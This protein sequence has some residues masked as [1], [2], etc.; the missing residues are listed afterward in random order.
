MK[1]HTV[2]GEQILSGSR[3]PLIQMAASIALFHHEKWD[4][5]GYPRG[6]KGNEIPLEARIVTLC[7]VYDALRS[8]RP[9][10][11]PMNHSAAL[12][13]ILKG[14]RITRPEQF[15]PDILNIFIEIESV[16][17]EIFDRHMK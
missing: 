2:I 13:A 7:D 17:A 15:D 10:K 6:L 8:E 9:Y 14:D 16:F 1:R 5:T 11:K 12:D 3:I 4:G